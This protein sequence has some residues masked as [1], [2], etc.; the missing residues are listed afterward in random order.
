MLVDVILSE[1][2]ID[3]PLSVTRWRCT[4]WSMAE[5][6]HGRRAGRIPLRASR[7]RTNILCAACCYGS[8]AKDH[9]QSKESHGTPPPCIYQGTLMAAG[10][11]DMGQTPLS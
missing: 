11:L 2:L 1:I 3:D 4:S 8:N 6:R 5:W 10:R 7:R 9:Y